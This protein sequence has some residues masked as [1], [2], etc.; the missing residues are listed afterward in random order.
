MTLLIIISSDNETAQVTL[1]NRDIEYAKAFARVIWPAMEN[2][3]IMTIKEL[4]PSG[5]FDVRFTHQV[6]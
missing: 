3:R 5:K 4:Q 1:K 2:A 6:K